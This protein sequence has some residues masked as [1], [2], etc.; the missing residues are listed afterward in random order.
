MQRL[1]PERDLKPRPAS[2]PGLINTTRASKENDSEAHLMI[3]RHMA[4]LVLDA[5]CCL[6]SQHIRG[7]LNTVADL[8][9]F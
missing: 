3:A 6:A 9:S 7:D 4:L 8:L 5:N 2:H 1:G